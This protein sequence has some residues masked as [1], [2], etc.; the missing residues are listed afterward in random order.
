M[1]Q[2]GE[3][4]IWLFFISGSGR[5]QQRAVLTWTTGR[6]GLER[7]SL[8]PRRTR[9]SFCRY[10]RALSSTSASDSPW[11]AGEGQQQHSLQIDGG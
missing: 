10:D 1:G 8:K 6:F 2:S 7:A 9:R 3:H 5:E 4:S 11:K